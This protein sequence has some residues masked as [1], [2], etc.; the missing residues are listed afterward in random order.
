MADSSQHNGKSNGQAN[1]TAANGSAEGSA[2][3]WIGLPAALFGIDGPFAEFM[4]T[5]NPFSL[6]QQNMDL[7]QQFIDIALGKSTIAPDPRDWRFQDETWSKNPFYRRLSQAYLAMTDAVEKLI[8]ED[9][10]DD[11]RSR[12]Q[13]AVDIVTS[14]FSP[15]NTLLGNPAAA[16]RA[17]ETKGDSVA[18]GF[19]NFVD[20]WLNNEGMPSQVDDSKFQ[21]GKNLGVTPGK[22]VHRTDMF[23]LIQYTPTCDTVYEIPVL[24][25]PPQIGRFYFTDLAPG[26][27]FAEYAVSQGLNHFVVSWRNPQ[28]EHRDWGLENY[29]ESALE[30][31]ETVAAITGTPKI[32]LIAFCAGGILSS[33]VAAYL[34]DKGKDTINTLALCVTML[35][36]KVNASIGAFRLPAM[37]SVAKAQSEMKGVLGG[38][39]LHKV[40]TW[41]RPNDLVWNYWVNNYLMG[42]TPS[43]FDILAW[44]KDNTNLPAQLHKDFLRIFEE[45]LLVKPGQFRALG[46][47]IDLGKIQCDNF[48]VGAVTDHLTPW[49]ACYQSCNFLGGD[50]TFA[51]S[52]GGHVAA[53]V[54]P[55]SNPKAHHFIAPGTAADAD[56]WMETAV[57]QKGSWWEGWAKWVAERSG[58]RVPA[59]KQQGSKKFPPLA[60]APGDYVSQ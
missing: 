19:R 21:V 46:T 54:N 32:N 20:D 41:L 59:P 13:L 38:N 56:A 3:P 29:I 11:D 35:N 23:E 58:K 39:D 49:K 16:L 17:I 9:L 50:S 44:N 53:L 25:I 31:V 28:P 2:G 8:P 37:L 7:Y 24:L 36:W 14:A 51:L 6:F 26:R 55:P 48:V 10:S 1:G 47:D 15:T 30:A 18:K 5:A 33:I 60:N 45:N 27:S 4:R 52:N 12:A 22:V 34:A 43:A 57:K 42:D 40:F